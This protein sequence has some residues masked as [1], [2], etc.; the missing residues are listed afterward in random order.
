MEVSDHIKSIIK[1]LPE[2]AGVYQFFDENGSILYVGKAKVLKNRVTSY[3]NKIKHD[4]IKT[5]LM[6]K[7][8]RDIKYSVVETESDALLLEDSLI[9]KF[10]PR[11]NIL[12]KDDKSYASIVIKNEPFPRV[13]STRQILDDGSTYFGPYTSGRSLYSILDLI[14]ELYPLRSCTLNLSK[15][16]IQA[17]KF[18]V[19][20]EY[21]LGNC[22]GPCVGKQREE[23]YQQG[24]QHI[25]R[26]IKG[27][28]LEAVKNL[29]KDMLQLAS[30]QKFEQAQQLKERIQT[31]ENF[32][33]KSTIVNTDIDNVEVFSIAS[34]A[35]STYANYMHILRGSIVHVYTAEVVRQLDETDEEV[36]AFVVRS[37]RERMNSKAKTALLPFELNEKIPGL[38]VTVPQRGDKK[39]LVDLSL[40]NAN[41]FL[42]EA[43]KRAA[44]LDPERNTQ[45]ILETMKKDLH[46]SE[47]PVHIECFDNSNIQ[48]TNPVSACVVFK[49]AKPSKSDYRIFNIQSVVGPDDFASMREAIYR[50]YSRLLQ[51][52]QPLPQLLI[53]DGGKGQLSSAMESLDLLG[54]R[55]KIAVIGIAKRLE[56]IFFP[57]DSIPIYLDKR[58][59]S[60][61]IIQHLRNEA[62]RY[63]LSKHRQRRSKGAIHSELENIA[64]VGKKTIEKLLQHFSSVA[65]IKSA[66][67]KEIEQVVGEKIAEKIKNYFGKAQ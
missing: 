8:I 2:K 10:K 23:D 21:H 12:L 62:H 4:S 57:G 32:Q 66:T 15:A 19:C 26:I 5:K 6:V 53:I 54:L 58:S 28:Y 30:E 39:K 25:K 45:R 1:A 67:Q 60:L 24:I 36:L 35:Q 34:D 43:R 33:A 56:E 51:E 49:N 40:K 65:R 64:G 48:G 14:K 27:E 46:L 42:L 11:Y 3:F 63:G 44:F 52:E 55:G 31:L 22:L 16:N 7:K 17:K 9:K 37:F 13:L 29:K 61:K 20:L 38:E 59:E 18:K 50:R 47:L 41:H